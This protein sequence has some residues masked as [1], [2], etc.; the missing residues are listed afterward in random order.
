VKIMGKDKSDDGRG[1]SRGRD[2]RLERDLSRVRGRIDRIDRRIAALLA[3]RRGAVAEVGEIKRLL[4]LPVE[5]PRR[6]EEIVSRI[7]G[8]GLEEEA[9]GYIE[10]VY[11]AIFR[12]SYAVERKE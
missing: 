8:S 9:K 5:D 11:R 3:R 2:P 4:G 10:A 7:R 1:L 12:C 6:E